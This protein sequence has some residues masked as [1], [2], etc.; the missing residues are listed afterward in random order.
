MNNCDAAPVVAH[1]LELAGCRCPAHPVM[2]LARRS[3]YVTGQLTVESYDPNSRSDRETDQ[4]LRRV[5]G[6]ELGGFE[7]LSR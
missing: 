2:C 3:S 1:S 5:L 4:S 7:E 6:V